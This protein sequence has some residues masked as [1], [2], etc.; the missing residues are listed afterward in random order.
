MASPSGLGK[1]HRINQLIHW[2]FNAPVYKLIPYMAGEMYHRICDE[3]DIMGWD[4]ISV[5]SEGG[6]HVGKISLIN[7]TRTGLFECC[8]ELNN[9]KQDL[10]IA[11]GLPIAK[12]SG[13]IML[14]QDWQYILEVISG[15]SVRELT[16][17]RVTPDYRIIPNICRRPI[18][19]PKVKSYT[20]VC[21]DFIPLLN[22]IRKIIHILSYTKN[23]VVEFSVF[24]REVGVLNEKEIF[25][26]YE[27]MKP[28]TLEMLP[29]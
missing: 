26:D 5:R 19:Y 4:R 22:V 2:G 11:K 14:N 20:D 17:G 7:K 3:A 24:N 16:H 8:D 1:F 12:L 6:T 23:V 18:V 27:E 13:T 10:I 29:G 28:W 9:C 25:W 21:D 15:K